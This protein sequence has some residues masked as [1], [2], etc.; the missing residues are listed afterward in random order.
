MSI[1]TDKFFNFFVS[2]DIA[3]DDIAYSSARNLIGTCLIAF[4][5]SPFFAWIYYVLNY[6]EGAI[7]I[8]LGDVGMLS[9]LI[10]LKYAKSVALANNVF[11]FSLT[12]LLVWLSYHLGGLQAPTTY[13]LILPALIASFIA[14]LRWGL[15]W[16]LINL[17]LIIGF[18]IL[19]LTEYDFPK[20]LISDMI[21]LQMIGTTGLAVVVVALIYFYEIDRRISLNKLIYLAYHDTLTQLPNRL[22]YEKILET[23][24]YHAKEKSSEFAVL[25][26]DI[27][28][29]KR[30]NDLF[31]ETIGNLLLNEIV[32]RIKNNILH[33]ES[34]ARVGG[35][36]FKLLIDIDQDV[37]A[38]KEIADILLSALK[39]PY[40]INKNEIN[41][42][43]SIGI[44][45][46]VPLH[47]QDKLIDRYVDSALLYA[48]HHGGDNYQFYTSNL[49]TE[50][51]LRLEIER[52]LPFAISANELELCF[53]PQFATTDPRKIASLEVLLRWHNKTL[54]EV[55]PDIFIPVAEKIGMIS[56]LGNWVM[57]ETCKKYMEWTRDKKFNSNISV[58]I[59]I[60]P[61][62]LYSKDFLMMIRGII[63]ETGIPPE[64]IELEL[65]ETAI[66]TNEEN[67]I[68]VLKKLK[69]IGICT[70]I[71]DFGSGYT[72][73]SYL[74]R[75]PVTGV[76]LDKLLLDNMLKTRNSA[77]I[78]ESII[79]LAHKIHLKVVAEGV[80]TNEQ[81]AYLAE[82][83]CDYVQGYFLS[84]PLSG[85]EV[86]EL[87][88]K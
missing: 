52:K 53:Q 61:A 40:S 18:Y 6:N 13:W 85:E 31:G 22:A 76:K 68:Q 50:E 47:T 51:A 41:I 64:K 5:A 69:E 14:G 42:T 26:I 46:Y 4:V 73:L 38:I 66:I 45:I 59:N 78:I 87:W 9:S 17:V 39:I 60:S 35:D 3:K 79:D 7:A 27:D 25:L 8:L 72:S 36:Q 15:I 33:T 44:A 28:D 29:F 24:I 16:C 86:K 80:E 71:D 81:L 82:M 70:V 62:Q 43:A 83:E 74:S 34:M 84:R 75:L 63:E 12:I 30:V 2:H 48:K 77:V 37:D 88:G 32:H 67:V 23:A 65:T 21:F 57:K 56:Y 55:S 20:P 1:Q 19:Q 49:A 54:G 10:V 58:A 11:V